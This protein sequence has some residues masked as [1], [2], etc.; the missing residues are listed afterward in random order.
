MGR[1]C[2]PLPA[3]GCRRGRGGVRREDAALAGVGAAGAA[4]CGAVRSAGL[5]G[6][7]AAACGAWRVARV[8]AGGRASA[9]PLGAGRARW[10]EAAALAC[11]ARPAPA[12][13]V[14]LRAPTQ[15]GRAG[16]LG[17]GRRAELRSRTGAPPPGPRLCDGRGRA[18]L[19]SPTERSARAGSEDPHPPRPQQGPSRLPSP[20]CQPPLLISKVSGA[21]GRQGSIWRPGR[22]FHRLPSGAGRWGSF[23][24]GP[25][26]LPPGLPP[27]S[28]AWQALSEP[29]RD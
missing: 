5:A 9:W 19:E 14:A 17:G 21:G 12:A 10:A 20:A 16:T 6:W 24:S 22:C 7:Q 15:P 26:G 8:V 28:Q 3:C 29:G 18:I 11:P 4:R 13:V 23:C 2:P 27:C 25:E 1:A